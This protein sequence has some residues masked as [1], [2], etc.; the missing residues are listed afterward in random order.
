MKQAKF[1]S[2]FNFLLERDFEDIC[3]LLSFSGWFH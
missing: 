1:D 2:F 3:I